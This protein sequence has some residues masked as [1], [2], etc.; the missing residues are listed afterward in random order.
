[1][2]PR[3]RLRSLR[4]LARALGVE[5]NV[6]FEGYRDNPAAYMARAAVFVSSSRWE[7]SSNVVLEALACGAPV[8]ATAAPTGVREVL[9]PSSLAPLTP[10]GNAE[11]LADAILWRLN[12]PRDAAQ[13]VARAR[14][15]PLSAT[16]DAYVARLKTEVA[17]ASGE[18]ANS[19]NPVSFARR[20]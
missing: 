9:A 11:A 8:V 17:L 4:K 15:Y 14:S 20:A 5:R 3:R 10:V 18:K 1:Q 6:R 2:G 12:A 19:Y 16:L 7:G 13:L